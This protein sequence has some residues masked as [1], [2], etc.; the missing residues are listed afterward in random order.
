MRFVGIDPSTKTGI[1]VLND[2]GQVVES[3][4]LHLP[5]GI[6]STS[7]ELQEYGREIMNLVPTDSLTCIE[8]FSYGSKGQGVS[9]QYGVGFSIR[10]AMED[11][12]LKFFEP[13]PSQVKKFAT[14]KG[15]TSK[16]NMVIPIFKLWGFED[17]SDN[18]RDAFVLAHIARAIQM[19][20]ANT[21]YQ[22]E[23]IHA[24]LSPSEK[25]KKGKVV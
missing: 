9:T 20:T 15:N 16:D 13:T 17:K 25:K 18:V 24:I 4:E 23:V 19:G 3:K 10:F 11:A 5:N 12:G 21:K 22:Q 6:Y 14:G 2:F 1:V 7:S 8:G